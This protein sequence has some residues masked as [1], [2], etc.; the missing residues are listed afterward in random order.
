MKI[1]LSAFACTPNTGSETGVGWRWAIELAAAGHDVVVLTDVSRKEKIDLFLKNN[2]FE[3]IKFE[4]F[5]PFFIKNLDL[6]SRTAQFVYTLWQYS[7]LLFA[8]KLHREYK[9]DR[10]IHITYGVFRHPSFLGFVGPAFMF[11]PLGGGE[12]APWVLKKSLPV[13]T[14]FFEFLRTAL[15]SVAKFNPMLNIAL[16]KATIVTTKTNDT[17]QALPKWVQYKT[18]VLS[19][20]GID[21]HKREVKSNPQR[22]QDNEP[23]QILYAGRL[24]GL[25]GVHFII[26]ALQLM[27]AEGL[28]VKLTIVGSGPLENW[29]KK[30]ADDLNMGP[31]IEWRAHVPQVELFDLYQKMH[32]LAFPSLHDSSGNVVLEALSFGLPVVCLDLGGP[33]TLVNDKC[34]SVIKTKGLNEDQLVVAI[35]EMIKFQYLNEDIRQQMSLAAIDLARESTWAS[36]VKV[37]LEILK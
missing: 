20:I 3:N 26:K 28:N 16:W 19:E 1:L 35:A 22:R 27:V 18:H 25:K 14:K 23:F 4:Y 7:L 32:C 33:A 13:K 21:M 36:R 34:A 6:N 24:L 2:T 29:L 30:V 11:G 8:K 37:A 31:Y 5:R 10:I 9:F 15:N 12:D 17:L